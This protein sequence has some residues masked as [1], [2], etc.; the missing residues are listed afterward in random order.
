MIP[1]SPSSSPAAALCPAAGL[2]NFDPGFRVTVLMG[3]VVVAEPVLTFFFALVLFR[4]S[5]K[6]PVDFRARLPFGSASGSSS[7][8][9][10]ELDSPSSEDGLSSSSSLSA[11][12][13]RLRFPL[14]GCTVGAYRPGFFTVRPDRRGAER[15]FLGSSSTGDVA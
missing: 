9:S 5:L 6:G 1:K 11:S 12:S 14:V 13:C 8:D 4:N 2:R 7:G 3:N 15:P 10:N